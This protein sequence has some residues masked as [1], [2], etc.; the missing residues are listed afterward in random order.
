VNV[1]THIADGVCEIRL[2]RPDKRNAITPEMWIALNAAVD[3]AEADRAVRVLLFSGAGEAFCAGAD[4]NA[5]SA[6]AMSAG[7][8]S[9]LDNPGGRFTARLPQIR[10]VMVAAVQGHAVGFGT[11]L[12]LQCDYVLAAPSARFSLP[13]VPRG[14]VPE[15]GSSLSLAQRVGP[16]RAAQMMLAAEAIDA[17]TAKDWALVTRV[18]DDEAQLL[19]E[20]RAVAQRIAA[21][22][23]SALRRT[24]ELLR[25]PSVDIATQ[26]ERESVAFTEQLRSAEVKEAIAAFLEKRKPDFSGL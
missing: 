16:L 22:P 20:A 23:P 24:R 2:N 7:V 17:A 11:T 19:S 4:L 6:D 8:P 3:A 12:L 26:I 5:F 9:G 10:Q 13:F 21:L 14:F 18:V 15:A 1:V 25:Q